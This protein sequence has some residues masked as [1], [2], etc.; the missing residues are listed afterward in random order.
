MNARDEDSCIEDEEK[1]SFLTVHTTNCN[2]VAEKS[3][4]EIEI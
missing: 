1:N 3:S 2:A 4:F